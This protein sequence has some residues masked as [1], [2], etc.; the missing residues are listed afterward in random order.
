M[1]RGTVTSTQDEA[2]LQ[3]RD[4]REPPFALTARHQTAGR[5]RLGRA[6]ASPED[7]SVSLTYVHRSGLPPAERGWFPLAAGLAAV[8]AL[9]E[10][11][12]L[13]ATAEI[14]LKWP[15]DLHTADGRKLGGILVE[16]RGAQT[17]LVGIGLNLR[18]PVHQQDGSAVPDAAWLRGEGGLCSGSGSGSGSG[19]AGSA[20]AADGLSDQELRERLEESL[21][22]ALAQ[23][24][25]RLESASGDGI[26]S[27]THDRYT[28]TCLT[29]GRHVRVDPLGDLGT[30]GARSSSWFGLARGVDGHGRL[31]VDREG[32]EGSGQVAVDVG[33]V[34]HLRLGQSP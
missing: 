9:G 10:V 17:V 2:T 34:R 1:R 4:G 6:F 29:V 30:G 5:G 16:G 13:R 26:R 11:L 33:D 23:E 32:P 25:A 3:L 14:G 22:T 15:N 19:S 28:V 12:G 18:G 27:G 24:L 20:G 7:S 8:T 21:V 31:V